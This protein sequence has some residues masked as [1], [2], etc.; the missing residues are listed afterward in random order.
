MRDEQATARQ[1]GT[2]GPDTEPRDG[3]ASQALAE[4]WEGLGRAQKEIDPK[5]FYDTRGS[6]LFEEITGLEEYYPTRTE[7][8]LLE[9]WSSPWVEESRPASLVE[10][11]AGSARKTRILLD[12]MRDHGCGRLYVPVDV[13]HE[14][15]SDTAR[16]IRS[17]YPD[18]AVTPAV[19]D[20]TAGL[21][22]PVSPP[23]PTWY[24]FLGGTLGNFDVTPATQLLRRVARRMRAADRFLLGADLRPGAHKTAADLV[25][26]YDDADGVTAAFNLNVLTVLNREFGS[27]F[28]LD[29]FTHRAVYRED[30]GR[31]EMHLV[32]ERPQI[33]RFPGAGAVALREGETILTEISCKYDRPSLEA[34]LAEAGLRVTRWVED[35]K[36]L[37]AL[38]M[39]ARRR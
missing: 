25:R 16:C 2:P 19:A 30:K 21:T 31:I 14:F 13:A 24:A 10:L 3:E 39:T 8:A 36:G 29:S 5:Y 32:S 6:E 34:V 35:E 20:I 12:A 4:V 27:D 37:F 17:E 1:G 28:D 38:V 18:L 7:R 23:G 11:G 33:V 15:L 22:L 26:A 9:R